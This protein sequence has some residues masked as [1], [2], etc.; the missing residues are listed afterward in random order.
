MRQ[1]QVSMWEGFFLRMNKHADRATY[2][3][4]LYHILCL[5]PMRQ[6]SREVTLPQILQMVPIPLIEK[7]CLKLRHIE[8]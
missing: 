2:C 1:T 4:L 5:S 6:V 8:Y 3:C 7:Y